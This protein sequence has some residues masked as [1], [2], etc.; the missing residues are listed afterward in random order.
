MKLLCSS[1]S[2]KVVEDMLC[3]RLRRC[4]GSRVLMENPS[5]TKTRQGWRRADSHERERAGTKSVDSLHP[6]GMKSWGNGVSQF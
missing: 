1:R 4:Q 5:A 3:D 2:Q 6:A